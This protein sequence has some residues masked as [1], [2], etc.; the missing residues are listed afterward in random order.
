MTLPPRYAAWMND[1]LGAPIPAEVNATCGSCAM[2]VPAGAEQ[3]GFSA[4]TKCCTFLPDLW[5]FLVGGVLLDEDPDAARGRA[6][7][8][9]RI[10]RGVA[11]TPLGLFRPPPYQILYDNSREAFG[12]NKSMLCPHYIDEQGGLCGVWRHRE[13]TCTTWFCKFVRGAVGKEFW[14]QQHQVLRAAEEAV[15]AWCLVELG[16]DQAA[17]E[18]LFRPYRKTRDVKVTAHD[19]DGEPSLRDLRRAWGGWLGRE[20]EFYV[21]CARLVAPLAWE[22]VLRL[23]GVELGIYAALTRRAHARLLDQAIP[24]QPVAAL[25]QIMPRGAGRVRLTT[26]SEMDALDV[27][28]AAASILSYF[29]GRPTLDALDDIERHEGIRVTPSLVRKLTDFGVLRD[30]K[31]C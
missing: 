31:S 17:M 21:E 18:Q 11:V 20:R 25:V 4:A 6:S 15:S 27:P 26:Y 29:D 10:A 5:N 22:D 28:A 24:V 1:L 23:G 12:K 9:E 19:L 13:S 2:V 7:V 14:A 16:V 30:A 8:E 3:P